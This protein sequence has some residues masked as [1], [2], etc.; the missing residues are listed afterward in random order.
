MQKRTVQKPSRKSLSLLA[1]ILALFLTTYSGCAASEQKERDTIDLSGT[2]GFRLDP[3]NVGEKEAWFSQAL[4]DTI[5]LPGTT[6]LAKKGSPNTRLSET[7]Y[8]TRRYPYQG[9]AWYSKQVRI[10]AGWKG[11]RIRLI[12]ERTKPSVVWVDGVKAGESTDITTP[13][14]HEL[15]SLLT[16]GEHRITL[17]ID[18]GRS[19]PDAVRNASHAYV[20]H[21]QTNWNGVIGNIALES[22]E[23]LFIEQI[24]TFPD[25][26]KREVTVEVVVNN[27]GESVSR[28][29]RLSAGA[30]NS[31]V[32]H[33]LKPLTFPIDVPPGKTSFRFI[34]PLGEKAQLWSPEHPVLYRLEA[35]IVHK[36]GKVEDRNSA[37]FGLRQFKTDGTQ[38]SLNGQR[39]FLRGKHDACVFP[40]TGFP[41]MDTASW[42]KVFRIAKAYGINHYRF[43]SW[44]PPAAAFLAADLEG[45]FMQ[46]ELPFWGSL[47]DNNPSLLNFLRKEGKHLLAEYGNHAS[48]VMFALGNEISGNP[49]AI[50]ALR[51]T[52]RES[53]SRPLMASGSNNFLGF[54]GVN[55]GDDYFTTCR[56][57]G[58]GPESFDTHT[59]SSFSFADAWQ[60]GVL[61]GMA[62]NTLFDY[63][64]AIASCTVPVIS[65]EA[66]QFQIYPDYSEIKKYQG[67]LAPRNLE[68][69]RERLV[70]AGMGSQADA[71]F[72]ASGALSVLCYKA[73]IEMSLRTPGFGGFQLLDLQDFPGQGTALV[74]I[75]NAF[76]ESK[77]LITPEKFREFCSEVVP[78]L[79][80]D[81]FCF[82]SDDTLKGVIQVAQYSSLILRNQHIHWEVSQS[83]GGTIA[84]GDTF[85]TLRPGLL[86]NLCSITV[87]LSE[88]ASAEQLSVEIEL[89]GTPYRNSYPVWVYPTQP[90]PPTQNE[91]LVTHQADARMMSALA[92]GRRVL[93]LPEADAYPQ[94]TIGGLFTPDY[95]N[96]R[97]FKGISENAKKPVSPGTLGLLIRNDHPLFKNFPT[98]FHSNWQWWHIVKESRPLIMNAIDSTFRPIVQP[99]DNIERN[100]RLGMLFECSVGAG[101]LMVCM[102]PLHKLTQ[103]PEC[104]QLY[105]ALMEYVQSEAFNPAF[106]VDPETLQLLFR[107]TA[108]QRMNYS[109]VENISYQ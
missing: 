44:C 50:T 3:T 30:W 27:G 104:R 99:I 65:H 32:R 64:G 61:N 43:H 86:T 106:V 15:S 49:A 74:G 103:Y 16:P 93:L 67:V 4:S 109:G 7:S 83:D 19:V 14:R 53:D 18:N 42:R 58:E 40:L 13:Q 52:L 33:N 55:P 2:W 76:M 87:P 6:D 77:N 28:K 91:I 11:D 107:G 45:I 38:F 89:T 31:P 97:M 88:I 57:G 23:T 26:D 102:S 22:T 96:Y 36:A 85:A 10:P 72:K 78:L 34:C 46:P 17:L 39:I 82:S 68:I 108:E 80:T 105:Y 75:L 71:F 69:F 95:W 35:A 20:E 21:T 98:E 41:P 9:K 59:R 48:L 84:S 94:V 63:S 29:I 100:H 101:K 37:L 8:L 12:L 25:L 73:D 54:R 51:D 66:G 5:M 24:R 60:G 92:A 81:R 62:P 56:T 90:A 47:Q 79:R 1:P 70:K